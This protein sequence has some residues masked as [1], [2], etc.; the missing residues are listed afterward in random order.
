[1]LVLAC[2]PKSIASRSLSKPCLEGLNIRDDSLGRVAMIS[3]WI[4]LRASAYRL[5]GPLRI[6]VPVN[7]PT[8]ARP[9]PTAMENGYTRY[10]YGLTRSSAFRRGVALR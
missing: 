10:V 6:E 8:R 2:C 1:M 5:R 4:Q 9:M 3:V 7:M